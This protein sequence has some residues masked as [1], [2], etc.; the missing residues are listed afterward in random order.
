MFFRGAV[1]IA[2]ALAGT[3]GDGRLETLTDP[4]FQL[5]QNEMI[6][7]NYCSSSEELLTFSGRDAGTM[8][9]RI[10]LFLTGQGISS[11]KLDADA[12]IVPGQYVCTMS[13]ISKLL[14]W[15]GSY[16]LLANH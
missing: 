7:L 8:L 9:Y 2:Q 1:S 15:C 11:H 4:S 10:R 12:L 16:H 5:L 6:R 13:L 14:R 3:V